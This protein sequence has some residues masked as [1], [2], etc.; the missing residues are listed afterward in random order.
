MGTPGLANVWRC[1]AAQPACGAAAGAE[2][3]GDA[4][5]IDDSVDGDFDRFFSCGGAAP[6]KCFAMPAP[7][8]APYLTPAAKRARRSPPPSLSPRPPQPLLAAPLPPPP[9]QPAAAELLQPAAAE[10]LQPAEALQPTPQ[11]DGALAALPSQ[12]DGALAALLSQPDPE[13]QPESQR[14]SSRPASPAEPPLLTALCEDDLSRAPGAPPLQQPAAKRTGGD[15]YLRRGESAGDLLRTL[16]RCSALPTFSPELDSLLGGGVRCG[17]VTQI[18]GPTASGKTLLCHLLCLSAASQAGV[19]VYVDLSRGYSPSMLQRLCRVAGGSREQHSLLRRVL[20]R[21]CDP[22]PF[23]GGSPQ[24][25]VSWALAEVLTV[26]QRDG[27]RDGGPR[28]VV[29]DSVASALQHTL[30]GRREGH[31]PAAR[32]AATATLQLLK[33]LAAEG[34]AVAVVNNAVT[35]SA[36]DGTKRL[37]P[38]LGS[39]WAAVPATTVWIDHDGDATAQQTACGVD[40]RVTVT[41]VSRQAEPLSAVVRIPA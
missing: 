36:R 41:N 16:A 22:L 35:G 32:R 3:D 34:C 5:V 31:T 10:L 24:D 1:R 9:L 39:L 28:L 30:N 18:A 14:R 6:A 21:R 13:R 8:A 17:E 26:L 29:V 15:A 33:D 38:A 27:L 12:S 4:D 23:P 19:A 2:E 40:R 25:S 37:Q 11:S 20:H 7:L